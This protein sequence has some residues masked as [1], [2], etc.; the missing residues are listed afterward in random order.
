MD[1]VED[2]EELGVGAASSVEAECV[3]E[4]GLRIGGW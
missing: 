2:G 1:E 3:Q 4:V